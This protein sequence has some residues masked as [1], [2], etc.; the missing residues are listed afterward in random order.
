MRHSILDEHFFK[1]LDRSVGDV[2]RTEALPPLCYT[3]PEF[4]EFEKEALFNHEWLCVGHEAW[5]K[6][7]GEYFTCSFIGEPILVA[8]TREGEIKAMSA[9][10]Q[11]RGAPIPPRPGPLL[12]QSLYGRRSCR[13]RPQNRVRLKTG[14]RQS[15]GFTQS[16]VDLG[17]RAAQER[18]QVAFI[19]SAA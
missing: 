10:C 19:A 12:L 14:R 5:V 9:V 2:N 6:D 16:K 18:R 7:P 13:C 15:D 17:P 4:Y 1:G 11:H 3:D 8:R